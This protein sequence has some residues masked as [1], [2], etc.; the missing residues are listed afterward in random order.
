MLQDQKQALWTGEVAKMLGVSTDT[1]RAWALRLEEKGF[2]FPR[3]EHDRR[4]FLMGHVMMFRYLSSL[5]Q[6]RKTSLDNAIDTVILKFAAESE[7]EIMP[8]VIEEPDNALIPRFDAVFGSIQALSERLDQQ[9]QTQ[10]KI[11]EHMQRQEEAQERRDQQLMQT[12]RE[13]QDLRRLEAE[14]IKKSFWR[15]LF[16]K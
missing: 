9:E 13:I 1:V 3:D 6:D 7:N 15:G 12:L 11:L 8:S 2:Q 5:T 14:Q 16:K 4:G 10:K